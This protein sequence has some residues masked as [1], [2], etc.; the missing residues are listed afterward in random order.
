M[1]PTPSRLLR[2]LCDLPVPPESVADAEL[3]ARFARHRDETAF[4][5][6]LA[7]HGSMVLNACRRALGDAHAAEDAFQA[8]FLVLAR[9]AGGLRHPAALAGWLYGV[10][11]RI[12]RAARRAAQ[13]RPDRTGPAPVA[14][15]ADPAPGP[16]AALTARDLLAAL[17]A[18]VQR[19]PEAY[20]L[21]VVLCVLEGLS[22]E[23]AARR[24]GWAPG[25]V[26]GR[27]ERGRRRLHERLARRGLT[28]SA[29]LGAAEVARATCLPAALAGATVRAAG[30]MAAGAPPVGLVS[31]TVVALAQGG[32]QSMSLSKWK[33]VL[34][35]AVI[36]LTGTGLARLTSD[37]PAETTAVA[38]DA[39]PRKEGRAARPKR[40]DPLDREL[41]ELR[42][43]ATEAEKLEDDLTE[44]VIQARQKLVE[45]EERLSVAQAEARLPLEPSAKERSLYG[46]VARLER[47]IAV[48]KDSPQRQEWQRQL[49][50]TRQHLEEAEAGRAL[51]R[52]KRTELVVELRRELVRLEEDVRRRERRRDA[53][54]EQMADRLRQLRGA[55]AGGAG[56]LPRSLEDKLEALRRELAELRREVQRLRRR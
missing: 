1:A 13:R 53:A 37:R 16:L 22:Q 38:A 48:M 24:L 54:R 8:T 14:E 46:D 28:L 47:T 5:A 17:E 31:K 40:A 11:S 42:K 44:Q 41:A 39:G 3:L 34:V 4:A 52:K 51:F 29:V 18:E 32:V 21:P 35:L 43:L 2:Q 15:P 49:K 55:T 56:R 10:A 36:G 33:V 7:R 20:R 30:Q 45:L 27:L 25:S 23:E 9:R 26:K 19:L 12:A 6:L 50:L